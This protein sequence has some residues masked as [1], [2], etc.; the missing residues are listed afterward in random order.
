M[1]FLDQPGYSLGSVDRADG[2][3]NR[4]RRVQDWRLDLPWT[5]RL[6]TPHAPI[7]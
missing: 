4:R 3:R 2:L 7:P 1:S 5:E 6:I